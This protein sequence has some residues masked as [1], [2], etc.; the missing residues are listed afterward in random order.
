[1]LRRPWC[2][3]AA[4]RSCRTFTPQVET[5]KCRFPRA[6][7]VLCATRRNLV[8]RLRSALSVIRECQKQVI[9]AVG[10]LRQ[11]HVASFG[12]LG[13]LGEFASRKVRRRARLG[14]F[15][16]GLDAIRLGCH[17][18]R[19]AQRGLGSLGVCVRSATRVGDF[20]SHREQEM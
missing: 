19:Q 12:G 16:L 5:F 1:M 17:N 8:D 4:E 20:V 11:D 13:E 10:L 14:P 6:G 18:G 2:Y 9:Q 7:K 15:R 3:G